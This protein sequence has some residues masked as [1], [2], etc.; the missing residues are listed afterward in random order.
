MFWKSIFLFCGGLML[1]A[2]KGSWGVTAVWAWGGLWTFPTK[3]KRESRFLLQSRRM[4]FE[5]LRI[6]TRSLTGKGRGIGTPSTGVSNT[7]TYRRAF[8][9]SGSPHQLTVESAM[10]N[11][12]VF[13]WSCCQF[14]LSQLACDSWGFC[15]TP[16]QCAKVRIPE[17]LPARPFDAV[18]GN[19]G[20]PHRV[21]T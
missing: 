10:L 16:N 4:P 15:P 12:F 11:L 20:L 7:R 2:A 19:R 8:F 6:P 5:I 21:H 9:R 13:T 3:D 17:M 18:D 14:F 1:P